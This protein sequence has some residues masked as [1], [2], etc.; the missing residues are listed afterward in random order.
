MTL[1]IAIIANALGSAALLAGLAFVMSRAA[2]L[3]PHFAVQAEA[4]T[5]ASPRR[6]KRSSAPRP[7]GASVAAGAGA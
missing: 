6:T 1:T 4:G 2:N 5:A 3:T 7:R